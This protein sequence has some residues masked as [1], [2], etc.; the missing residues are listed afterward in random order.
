MKNL[1]LLNES[2]LETALATAAE[3]KADFL[4]VDSIQV[5]S[6]ANIPG[7][8]GSVSQVRLCAEAILEFAKPKRLPVL[9]TGHVTKDGT[10][11]GPRVL[12]H[13]VDGVFMLEG[14]R[15][16]D[17]RILRGMKNRFGST[18]E[19][20]VFEMTEGGLAEV[21]N[22]SAK[23]MEQRSVSKPGV[24]VVCTIEGTRPLLVE[25][26][27]LVSKTRFGY[28]VRRASGFDVNRLNL[29]IAVIEQHCNIPLGEYDVY[30][31]VVG[32]MKLDEPAAD[33]GIVAAIVSSW[34]KKPISKKYAF[35]AE[36]S[37]S[38]EIRSVQQL[39]K[40]QKEAQKLGF[41]LISKSGKNGLA[42]AIETLFR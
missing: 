20:G 33:L 42:D 19:I 40:R 30:V 6:S 23:F 29:L 36:V 15:Y 31:N 10:L 35:A 39:E 7:G 25:V 17:F 11:A 5:M 34:K 16:Q 4:I 38:G 13:L 18:N 41:S 22:P 26:E 1:A 3:Q 9:L 37:L 8:A 12:E 28:P 32:G 14:D 27:A 24:A 2:N 21:K